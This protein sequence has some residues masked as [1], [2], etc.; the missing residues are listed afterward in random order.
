ML[1]FQK[2]IPMLN[3]DETPAELATLSPEYPSPVSV[4][5]GAVYIDDAPSPFK[6]MLETINGNIFSYLLLKFVN[7]WVLGILC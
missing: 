7:N 3:E 5:D 6:Q 4:L 2:S 1:S